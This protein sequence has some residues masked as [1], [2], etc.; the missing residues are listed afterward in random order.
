MRNMFRPSGRDP[1]EVAEAY[2]DISPEELELLVQLP[3]P[4]VAD[5]YHQGLNQYAPREEF[6]Y[7]DVQILA[8][9]PASLSE[10]DA[11]VAAA[12]Q[13]PEAPNAQRFYTPRFWV[14]YRTV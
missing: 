7:G 3:T 2:P 8:R 13:H 11:L 10:A 9:V 4:A 12:R 5:V 1:D 6:V 14:F